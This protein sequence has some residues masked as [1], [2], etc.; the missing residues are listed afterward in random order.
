MKLYPWGQDEIKISYS[1]PIDFSTLEQTL[2]EL[3]L[4]A[5]VSIKLYTWGWDEIKTIFDCERMLSQ[6]YT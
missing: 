5:V 6:S 4:L 3:Q 2:F 1:L